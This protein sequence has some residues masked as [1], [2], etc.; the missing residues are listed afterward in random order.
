MGTFVALAHVTARFALSR[1]QA[2]DDPF[3]GLFL[4]KLQHCRATIS[5]TAPC[6]NVITE[7]VEEAAN[8]LISPV[9]SPLG[10]RRA[11]TAEHGAPILSLVLVILAAVFGRL[12][13]G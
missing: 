9:E 12:A 6:P 2:L 10:L 3:A 13:L 7:G 11:K 5:A 8:R 1:F 4:M